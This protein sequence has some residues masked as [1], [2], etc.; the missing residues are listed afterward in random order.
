MGTYAKSTTVSSGQSRAEIERTLERYGAGAFMYGWEGSKAVIGF[1]YDSRRYRIVL[2]LPDKEGFSVTETG[3]L[4]SS[5]KA[6]QDA[7][8]QAC[9]QRWRAL[10][11]WV[12]AVL[13]ASEV[14]ITT[15]D[16]ALQPFILLPN[17]A[18]VGEWMRP[19]IAQVYMT[20]TMPPLLL[21]RPGNNA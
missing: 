8:E 18:T 4:R 21:D 10:A 2:M 11:L 16:Q 5:S 20:G 14:G 12:K 15:V 13:E 6:V 9:R 17:G 19:Q 3:R 7:W 1:E